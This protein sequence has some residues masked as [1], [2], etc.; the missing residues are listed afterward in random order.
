V[1]FVL[2]RTNTHGPSA[3]APLAYRLKRGHEVQSKSPGFAPGFACADPYARQTI[4]LEL[5]AAYRVERFV[6][7]GPDNTLQEAEPS[8]QILNVVANFV[9]NEKGDAGATVH[10]ELDH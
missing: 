3:N 9:T 6:R 2:G 8:M 5:E 1:K 10:P 4:S 7:G